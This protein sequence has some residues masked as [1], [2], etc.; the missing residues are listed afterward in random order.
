MTLLEHLRELRTR[1]FRASIA[2]VLG[3]IV[4]YLLHTWILQILQDPYCQISLKNATAAN[5]GV[6]PQGWRCEFVALKVTDPLLLTLKISL[7]SGL[8]VSSPFWMY[9]LWAFVAPGLHRSERRWAYVFAGLAAPLFAAGAVLAFIVVSKGLEFLISFIN[10][11]TSIMLEAMAYVDFVTGMMLVFGVAFEFPLGIML[12]N[13]A[14]I[15]SGKR[16]LGWWRIAVFIFFVFAAIATPTAD[17]FGMT[18]LALCMSLLYFGAVA[19]AL[20]NDKRRGRNRPSFAN[21]GDD[22]V[23][24]LDDYDVEPVEAA[25]PIDGYDPIDAPTPVASPTAVERPRPLDSR[26]DDVT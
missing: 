5:N 19:F 12:A 18:F 7:W 8:I 16:L 1:L 11:N 4:G 25:S 23:S 15:A 3:M 9:Q 6:L 17:P 20:V 13:I 10:P 26:Y 21:I 22:E 24:S 14:G 2:I